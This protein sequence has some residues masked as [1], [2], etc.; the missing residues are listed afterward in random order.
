MTGRLDVQDEIVG[1]LRLSAARS[2]SQKTNPVSVSR[3]RHLDHG[4]VVVAA[5]EELL[6]NERVLDKWGHFESKIDEIF[7]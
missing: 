2:A 6:A 5:S 1:R 3:V 4:V 7:H